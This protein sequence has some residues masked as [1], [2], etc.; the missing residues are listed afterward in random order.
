[1]ATACN[2]EKKNFHYW[3]DSTVVLAWIRAPSNKWKT[4]VANRV[5]EIQEL[6]NTNWEHVETAM[7]P[8]DLLSRGMSATELQQSDLWW[9]GP[10]WLCNEEIR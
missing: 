7:N 8:A 2:I 3:T 9:K 1:M 6:T 10:H 5:A 4:F